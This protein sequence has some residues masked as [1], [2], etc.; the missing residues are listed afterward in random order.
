MPSK[1]ISK[2]FV[3]DEVARKAEETRKEMV[4]HL[5]ELYKKCSKVTFVGD[6]PSNTD[7]ERGAGK[8]GW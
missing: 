8:V 2:S 1:F 6:P 7:S 5:E 3:R 4:Q